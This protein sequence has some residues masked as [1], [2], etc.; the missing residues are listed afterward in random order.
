MSRTFRRVKHAYDFYGFR[1]PHWLWWAH[2]N[3]DG[4]N[5]IEQD[6]IKYFSDHYKAN[7]RMLNKTAR[8][9]MRAESR[10]YL[11]NS[12]WLPI[13]TRTMLTSSIL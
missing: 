13:A 12:E 2:F 9:M 1:R 10:S 5:G 7:S 6:A 11:N 4:Q 3:D 8:Q